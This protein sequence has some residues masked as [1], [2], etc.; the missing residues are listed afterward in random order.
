MYVP[1]EGKRASFGAGRIRSERNRSVE[2]ACCYPVRESVVVEARPAGAAGAAA[3]RSG[4]VPDRTI[5]VALIDVSAAGGDGDGG[6]IVIQLLPAGAGRAAGARS[7]G[8]K[9]DRPI[10]MQLQQFLSTGG[11]RSGS[12]VV[13]EHLP[14][15]ASGSAARSSGVAPNGA[16]AM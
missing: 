7:A 14:A 2:S 3:G 9:P 4:V 16:I 13:I 8:I 5:V 11:N 12:P 6:G 15:R 1:P 10:A